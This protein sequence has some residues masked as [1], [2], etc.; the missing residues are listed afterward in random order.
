MH[1][2]SVQ[3]RYWC[4]NLGIG[5]ARSTTAHLGNDIYLCIASRVSRSKRSKIG[6]GRRIVI[7]GAYFKY[8]LTYSTMSRLLFVSCHHERLPM[9]PS[10]P[11]SS[12]HLSTRAHGTLISV[13]PTLP[14][15]P[16]PKL[17]RLKRAC[18]ATVSPRWPSGM[19]VTCP[20][21]PWRARKVI[22]HPR[23]AL[24][25]TRGEHN[26]HDQLLER[27]AFSRFAQVA[28]VGLLYSND[29]R[30]TRFAALPDHRHTEN[31]I[32]R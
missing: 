23:R 13:T 28:F 9:N 26:N 19:S 32:G 22:I 30:R 5:R 14:P 1:C 2:S 20:D 29:A 27:A 3:R 21:S 17:P 25:V 8:G 4:P 10:R 11:W 18:L 31:S 7:I 15:R 12:H 24:R 16:K 6:V